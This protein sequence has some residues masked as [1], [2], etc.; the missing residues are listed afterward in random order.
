LNIELLKDQ[1]RCHHRLSQCRAPL[2][3]N[4]MCE[5]LWTLPRNFLLDTRKTDAFRK[6]ALPI[7]GEIDSE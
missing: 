4:Q 2:S 6:L 7:R 3:P 5:K 1:Q